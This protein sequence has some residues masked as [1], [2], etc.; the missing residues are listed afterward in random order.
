[1]NMSKFVKSELSNFSY[2]RR[3]LGGHVKKFFSDQTNVNESF[4]VIKINLINK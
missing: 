1:M 4:K 3:V 2:G